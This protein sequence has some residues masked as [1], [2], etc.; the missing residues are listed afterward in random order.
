VAERLDRR[1]RANAIGR[2]TRAQILRGRLLS[3]VQLV[4]PDLDLFG[5]EARPPA[6]FL[7]PLPAPVK[8]DLFGAAAEAVALTSGR[9]KSQELCELVAPHPPEAFTE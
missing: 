5:N 8:L 7:R 1:A 4:T 6:R 2:K 3:V 9:P